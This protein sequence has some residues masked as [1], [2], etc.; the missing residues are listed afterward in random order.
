LS[1]FPTCLVLGL[2]LVA[3]ACGGATSEDATDAVGEEVTTTTAAPAS[4]TAGPATTTTVAIA[5]AE[6][7]AI[8]TG[9]NGAVEILARPEAV[10]SL[11]PTATEILFAIDAGDQVIAADSLSDYPAEAP[12]TSLS[13]FEP[14]VEAIA[15]LGPDLVVLSFDPGDVVASFDALGI[16]TLVQSAA[17][18]IAD[19][20]EQMLQLGVA[21]GNRDAAAATIK[22]M[23]ADID[24]VVA[25]LPATDEP[26]RY[27]HELDDTYYS[28][29]STTFIGE[30]YS[31]LG[32][33][34]IADGAADLNFGYPQ[35]SA[36]FILEADPDVILLADTMC[37]GQD[38][39]T[40]SERPGWSNLTAIADGSIVELEDDV[41][42]RWGPRIVD[43]LAE[44]AAILV[45]TSEA[46]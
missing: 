32:M 6:F 4:A 42:S 20:Y 16:P 13:A 44:V 25:T 7:P 3:T 12:T 24:E 17:L 30:I 41:A 46:G 5:G 26:I 35:L 27:Y 45:A 34:S 28:V 21:T 23:Q 31:L 39:T 22:Q 15:E 18:S 11:S 14:N 43:L 33:I 19:T 2:A 38:A 1:R 29:A 36:E 40:V 37:C 10:V 8:A 9:D